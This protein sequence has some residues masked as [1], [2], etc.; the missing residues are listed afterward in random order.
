MAESYVDIC[1]ISG[2]RPRLL[3]RTVS[4]FS[5]SVFENLPI[6]N[7]FVNIDPIFGSEAEAEECVSIVTEAFPSAKIFQPDRPGFCAAVK[8]VWQATRAD[9]V[10]HLEDDWIALRSFGTDALAPFAAEDVAQVALH[11]FNQHWD[12]H[13]KGH[14]FDK[15]QYIEGLGFKIPTLTRIPRFSTSPSILRGEFARDAAALMDESLDPE[16]QFYSGLNLALER[17]VRPYKNYIFS[18]AATPVIRDIGREWRD[19]RRILKKVANGTSIWT[20][21]VG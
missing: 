5:A 9:F 20:S 17:Y 7:V 3:E 19:E 12:V 11:H 15:R 8:R 13:K 14:I 4:S 16:K 21:E 2:R 1:I 6:G 18:P 10:F